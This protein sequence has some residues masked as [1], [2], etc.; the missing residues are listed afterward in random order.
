MWPSGTQSCRQSN[1]AAY[2]RKLNGRPALHIDRARISAGTQQHLGAFRE[3]CV[4][5][6]G[7]FALIGDE[8]QRRLSAMIS[9]RRIAPMFDQTPDDPRSRT[10]RRNMQ[11]RFTFVVLR[12]NIRPGFEQ[13][14]DELDLPA[15]GGDV[16]WRTALLIDLCY[17]CTVLQ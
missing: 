8:M 12:L 1:M 15:H 2:G 11:R 3:Q 4:Q 16:K 9:G 10:A 5:F 17:L 13:E 6:S 14:L 7:R